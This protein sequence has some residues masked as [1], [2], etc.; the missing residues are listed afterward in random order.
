[1]AAEDTLAACASILKEL[2]EYQCVKGEGRDTI[3]RLREKTERLPKT[4]TPSSGF[5]DFLQVYLAREARLLDKESD[6]V[7]VETTQQEIDRLNNAIKQ[8]KALSPEQR[9]RFEET[10][11]ENKFKRR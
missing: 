6:R 1:M 9:I 8:I 2:H 10:L 11:K 3:R 4:S 7:A 5:I